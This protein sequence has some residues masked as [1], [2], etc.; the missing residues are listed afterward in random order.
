MLFKSACTILLE[1]MQ[2]GYCG[3][4]KWRPHQIDIATMRRTFCFQ[5]RD[6]MLQKRLQIKFSSL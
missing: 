3:I 1:R 5:K 2:Q 6:K 4:I